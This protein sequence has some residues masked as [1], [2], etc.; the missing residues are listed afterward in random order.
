MPAGQRRRC[1]VPAGPLDPEDVRSLWRV[2]GV[3]F[4]FG[5]ASKGDPR[6]AEIG[7]WVTKAGIIAASDWQERFASY[8][9]LPLELGGPTVFLPFA[10]GEATDVWPLRS[11]A[12]VAVHEAQ[13]AAQ[14]QLDPIGYLGGY[15]GSTA[16]RAN[17]EREA[18]SAAECVRWRV[19][20]EMADPVV[21]TSSLVTAYGC[22]LA[23]AAVAA[24]DL[25]LDEETIR[26]G[27]ITAEAAAVALDW[28]RIRTA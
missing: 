23:D 28:W 7:R 24:E 27:G 17:Y 19:W 18:R 3:R 13:H 1:D 25:R 20:E 26:A 9:P 8:L 6:A 21:A 14:Y 16:R 10:P 2:L 5:I 22:H 11:Q 12:L 4:G 15:L